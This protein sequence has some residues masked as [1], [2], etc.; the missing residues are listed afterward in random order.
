MFR[1]PGRTRRRRPRRPRHEAPQPTVV[2]WWP[3]GNE[4]LPEVAGPYRTAEEAL[5][6]RNEIRRSQQR[7]H[8]PAQATVLT[9][10]ALPSR[11]R[12][13]TRNGARP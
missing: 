1:L 13:A 8:L 2:L 3:T 10:L 11:R 7:E 6:I 5:E 9:A 12:S 4:P